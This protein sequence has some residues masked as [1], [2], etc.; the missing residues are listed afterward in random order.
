MGD[1]RSAVRSSNRPSRKLLGGGSYQNTGPY[2]SF[3]SAIPQKNSHLAPQSTDVATVQGHTVAT[4]QGYT[5]Q[6]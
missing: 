4:F 2:A 6:G 3:F 1:L 5:V